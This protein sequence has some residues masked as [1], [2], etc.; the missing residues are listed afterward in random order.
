MIRGLRDIAV[1]LLGM[2]S[3]VTVQSESKTA[4]RVGTERYGDV[5]EFG[6]G[7]IGKE[8][9]KNDY[10]AG[11]SVALVSDQEVIW[12]EGFGWA[13]KMHKQPLT[14][15]TA[16]LMG[17]ISKLF[18]SIAVMQLVEQ[19]KVDLDAPLSKY[20]PEFSIKTHHPQWPQFTVR[21]M[22]HHSSGLPGDYA[23]GFYLESPKT[24]FTTEYRY[25]PEK[26]GQLYLVNPP[27]QVHA[28]SNLAFSL[29]GSL[30]ERVSGEYFPDYM[31]KHIL[32]QLGMKH[33][34][35]LF[36]A[37]VSGRLAQG[38]DG[39]SELDYEY[40]RDIAAGSLAATADDIARFMIALLNEGDGMLGAAYLEEMLSQQNQSTT[41]HDANAPRMGLGFCIELPGRL[42]GLRVAWHNGGIRSDYALVVTLPEAKL[43]M[44]MMTSAPIGSVD[45][46]VENIL[47]RAYEAK[48]G[49]TLPD[50]QKPVK[51]KLTKAQAR[52]YNGY[53]LTDVNTDG[54]VW[55]IF[56]KGS[57]L[58]V[59]TG[60]K[61]V[62]ELLPYERNSFGFGYKLMG[63]I[64][65]KLA[66]L[67]PLRLI[68]LEPESQYRLSTGGYLNVI[69]GGHFSPI[70]PVPISHVWKQRVGKYRVDNATPKDLDR[71]RNA[72]KTT[73]LVLEWDENSGF[74][75]FD[76]LPLRPIS[77]TQAISIGKGRSRGETLEVRANGGLFTSGYH[78]SKV[79]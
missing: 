11:V 70:E 19:G 2:F 79:P 52:A 17:S 43:G 66:E 13:S 10:V 59:K 68:E 64:P 74:L 21:Q 61:E 29:L 14:S 37:R 56:S 28:Y 45:Q 58:R 23:E 38:H 3:T 32:D 33:S 6:R 27:N 62:L 20:V 77:D 73:E 5:V 12:S 67:T 69:V 60:D 48:M 35:F 25:L 63:L 39:G 46:W 71:R 42:N 18:T 30:V 4:V 36:D 16:M 41:A 75:L 50:V 76:G 1:F 57:A 44:A 55:K 9:T 51:R 54:G 78:L 65:I 72:G 7:L 26:V 40:I 15:D 31:N 8:L 24:V 34:S 47:A 49:H 53:Y 22:M